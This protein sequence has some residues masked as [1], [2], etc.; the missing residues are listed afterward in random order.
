MNTSSNKQRDR[1]FTLVEVLIVIVI[2][3]VLATVVVLSVRGVTANAEEKACQ[4][5]RKTISTA[6]EAYFAQNRTEVLPAT[7]TGNNRYEA[8]LIADDFLTGSSS[9]WDLDGAG[10]LIKTATAAC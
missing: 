1:G 3:G 5:E 10:V 2:L 8:T 4:S 7:G 6:V 9:H